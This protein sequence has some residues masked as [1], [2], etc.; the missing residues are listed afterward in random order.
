M[1]GLVFDVAAGP[2]F[3]ILF[4]IPF[5]VIVG[6]V[7]LIVFTVKLIKRARSQG[8]NAEKEPGSGDPPGEDG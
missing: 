3:L 2:M 7:I 4:G 6:V 5:L 8:I 1:N